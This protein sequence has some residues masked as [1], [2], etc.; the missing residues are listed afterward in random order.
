MARFPPGGEVDPTPDLGERP[1][2]SN[3]SLA[4]FLLAGL[5][6][7]APRELSATAWTPGRENGLFLSI[8]TASPAGEP[9]YETKSTTN[10]LSTLKILLPYDFSRRRNSAGE[11]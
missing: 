6:V 1:E 4:A 8:G 2:S 9:H 3:Y 7:H 10:S 5:F 11:S